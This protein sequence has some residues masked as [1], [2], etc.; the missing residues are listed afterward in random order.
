MSRLFLAIPVPQEVREVAG[1]LQNTLRTY[2]GRKAPMRW[3]KPEQMHITT[4]FLGE[5]HPEEIPALESG[6]A[7]C[8]RPI[9]TLFTTDALFAFPHLQR[10]R[11]I[12]I[13]CKEE[14]EGIRHVHEVLTDF[15]T[16][17]GIVPSENAWIPHVTVGRIRT[18]VPRVLRLQVTMHTSGV[19]VGWVTS[20][21]YMTFQTPLTQL[22][23]PD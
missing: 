11:V 1:E 19:I 4:H 9:E 15:F 13:A 16:E 23:F 21:L 2:Y 10:P 18:L 7:T 3:T 8:L 14:G 5:C 22:K 12:V 20:L 6:I 17:H